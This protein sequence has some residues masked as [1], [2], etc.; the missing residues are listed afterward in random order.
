[1]DKR[2]ITAD[3]VVRAGA[4]PDGVRKF[5]RRCNG[6]AA[7]VTVASALRLARTS[8]ERDWIL[9]AADGFGYGYGYGYG[10]GD[11]DG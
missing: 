4:C 10:D 11:G 8:D 2:V 5:I 7:A 6:I 1:M 3:D 9:M